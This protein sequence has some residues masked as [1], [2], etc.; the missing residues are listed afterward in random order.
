MLAIQ[1]F[2][3]QFG[4]HSGNVPTLYLLCF[5]RKEDSW[6]AKNT[7]MHQ[8]FVL[9]SHYITSFNNSSYMQIKLTLKDS[10]LQQ[11][12]PFF[13]QASYYIS[14]SSMYT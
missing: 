2:I 5:I 8:A 10:S 1:E 6:Y 3:M 11:I 7:T 12:Q 4:I 9:H 13:L 14:I